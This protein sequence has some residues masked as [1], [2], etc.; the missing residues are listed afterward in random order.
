[1]FRT[2][3]AEPA[4]DEVISHVINNPVPLSVLELDLSTPVEGWTIFLASRNIEIVLDDLGRL[5]IS[6]V[7]ARQLFDERREAE[8]RKREAAAAAEREAIEADQQ[9]R[10]T[11]WGGLPWYE[12][13]G[14]VSPAQALGA[15]DRPAGP[16][17]R[18]PVMDFLDNPDGGTV[19]HPITPNE[20]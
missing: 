3:V 12:L 13:P 6:R 2:P 8:A 5:S 19:F 1:M 10:S 11:L 7:D 20:W 15:A 14:G 16:R 18:P 4:H 9:F 17:R